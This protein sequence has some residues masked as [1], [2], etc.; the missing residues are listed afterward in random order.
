MSQSLWLGASSLL[1]ADARR[2]ESATPSRGRASAAAGV[3]WFG[4]GNLRAG[5]LDASASEPPRSSMHRRVQSTDSSSSAVSPPPP[6][7]FPPFPGSRSGRSAGLGASSP[8]AFGFGE[9][10]SSAAFGAA[11]TGSA[12][13]SGANSPRDGAALQ[14]TSPRW[15]GGFGGLAMSVSPRE[16]GPTQLTPA[17]ESSASSSVA[18]FAPADGPLALRAVAN[19]ARPDPSVRQV[20]DEAP[21]PA[22]QVSAARPPGK[23]A[24]SESKMRLASRRRS[25]TDGADSGVMR[26]CML[27]SAR[28]RSNSESAMPPGAP[29]CA[30]DGAAC[31]DT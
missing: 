13:G 29:V 6:F 10:F 8:A 2:A 31:M 7:A 9:R 24:G 27:R 1:A 12:A 17:A 4:A 30:G 19:A 5:S 3:G 16:R 22:A 14:Q 18:P 20:L 15:L 26:A 23:E 25:S 21:A 11:P 28:G